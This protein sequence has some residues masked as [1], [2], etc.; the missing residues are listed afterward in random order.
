MLLINTDRNTIKVNPLLPSF[1][2]NSICT[3]QCTTRDH[4]FKTI[5]GHSKLPCHAE[6]TYPQEPYYN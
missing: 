3:E 1:L 2:C 6:V 4:H 5:Y